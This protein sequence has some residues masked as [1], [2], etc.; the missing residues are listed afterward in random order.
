MAKVTFLMFKTTLHSA[1]MYYSKYWLDAYLIISIFPVLTS[2]DVSTGL[3]RIR[4]LKLKIQTQKLFPF[5]AGLLKKF[6]ILIEAKNITCLLPKLLQH[7]NRCAIFHEKGARAGNRLK[8]CWELI[9]ILVWLNLNDY[10]SEKVCMVT[11][12][13]L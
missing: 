10:G 12:L 6:S 5:K 4:S 11:T 9:Q 13:M 8:K 2:M 1:A 3:L 7:E